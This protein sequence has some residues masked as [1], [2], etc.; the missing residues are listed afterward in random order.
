V[1][2]LFNA[3]FPTR[4]V[5]LVV[6]EAMLAT[7]AFVVATIVYQGPLDASITLNYEYGF[8][9]IALIVVTLILCMYYCD[10]YDS[11]ILHNQRE[12][13]TRMFQAVAILCCL[14]GAVYYLFPYFDMGG[15]VFISGAG[16]ALILF[17]IWRHAFN[18]INKM[19]RFSERC[20]ILGNGSLVE[21]LIAEI[22]SRAE[23]G[24]RI[25]D[26]GLGSILEEGDPSKPIA[27]HLD[28]IIAAHSVT[29]IIV[30]L[31]ERRGTL[32]VEELL[33]LKTKG[34][35]V[36]D[37]VEVYET[38]SGK[39]PPASVRLSWLLFSPGFQPSRKLLF[40]KRT[41]SL[42]LSSICL[43]IASPIMVL[44]VLA[45]R[46]DSP[47]PAIFKQKRVGLHGCVFTLFKFRS[48]FDGVDRDGNFM[49][50]AVGD[51]RVTRVG[52][53][54]RRTRLDELPQLFNIFLGHMY[55]VG[56]RPFVPNQEEECV[57]HIPFYKQ[58]WSIRSG[59]TGWAQV[60][61]DYCATI[62]DNTEKLAYDL[63]YIKHMSVGLD[64][65][66]LFKT[67]KILL[68]GRGG[69]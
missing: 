4:T 16:L 48:M 58:R 11:M 61:R 69:R 64:L 44:L 13:V 42:I 51:P 54:L 26:N 12:V 3:Y 18:V 36:Q 6:S 31:D 30:A 63:F 62:A 1:I 27:S 5:I 53:I 68:L 43:L 33:L 40:Y 28:S 15:I 32:P 25:I 34:I 39:I 45:I 59:A 55:F 38:L 8:A 49:A 46:L 66:I 7:M 50:A 21:T 14:F 65:L 19:E 35:V 17:S 22:G 67:F 20:L 23:L 57:R 24:I 9:K 52:R 56:P 37:G 41:F 29:R 47:G 10:M 60:N 2:K